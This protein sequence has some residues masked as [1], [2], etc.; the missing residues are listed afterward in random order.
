M[1]DFY[2]P[3]SLSLSYPG[4]LMS[5]LS[6]MLMLLFVNIFI[7]SSL[8]LQ[9]HILFFWP[10]AFSSLPFDCPLW[11][12]SLTSSYPCFSRLP[13]QSLAIV[14]T[15][16][17]PTS[18]ST[19]THTHTHHSLNSTLVCSCFAALCCLIRSWLWRSSTMETMTLF[20][21]PST[22]SLTLSTSFVVCWSS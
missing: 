8:V 16:T 12:P 14:L 18:P 7:G 5:G 17:N 19:H 21:T 15:V 13:L 20:G 1:G 6:M 22:S 11:S 2:H 4:F 9:V 10:P 3:L